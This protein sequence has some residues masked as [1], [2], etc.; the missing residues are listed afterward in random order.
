MAKEDVKLSKVA[1]DEQNT[2]YSLV[3]LSRLY[4]SS[5]RP[6]EAIPYLAEAEKIAYSKPYYLSARR[7]IVMM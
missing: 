5:N 4:I 7:R 1:K 3:L 6:D 2:I